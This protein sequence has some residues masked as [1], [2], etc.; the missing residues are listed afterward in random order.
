MLNRSLLLF[1]VVAAVLSAA[2][3]DGT[4][5]ISAAKENVKAG[6]DVTIDVIFTNTSKN[7]IV[8]ASGAKRQD[9]GETDYKVEV[10]DETSKRALETNYGHKLRTGEDPPGQHTVIVGS[11]VTF[12]VPPRG[13]VKNTI[14]VN[15][16]YELSKPGKYEIHVERLDD[17]GGALIKSNAITITVEK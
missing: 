16:L 1:L 5:K 6:S 13:T 14:L 3:D 15:K 17:A 10:Q 2:S 8:F 11:S 9:Q 7:H 12:D 4:I